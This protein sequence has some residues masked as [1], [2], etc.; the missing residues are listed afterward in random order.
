MTPLYD[1]LADEH[2]GHLFMNIHFLIS[3]ALYW[4]IIGVDAAPQQISPAVKLVSLMGSL[5]FHAWFGITLMQMQQILAEDYYR[6]LALPWHVDLLADQNVG[7]A[8]A[9]ALGE[10]PMF[11][12]M[13]A[14]FVQCAAAT[15]RT[16]PATTATRSATMTPSWRPTTPCSPPAATRA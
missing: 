16:P 5:P 3:A 10:V 6:E 9:W 13:T 14:L 7:G 1:Y 12:V 15:R 11:I 4:V 2:A 8:V